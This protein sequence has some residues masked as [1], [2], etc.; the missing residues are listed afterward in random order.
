MPAAL[1]VIGASTLVAVDGPLSAAT[2]AWSTW[3]LLLDCDR[4]R[5][6][7]SCM[8]SVTRLEPR[9]LKSCVACGSVPVSSVVPSPKSQT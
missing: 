7:A 8:V 1:S 4:V 5:P 3:R 2:G 9:E 6:A